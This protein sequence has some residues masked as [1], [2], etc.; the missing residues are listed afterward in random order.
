MGKNRVLWVSVKESISKST[1]L[2][3]AFTNEVMFKLRPHVL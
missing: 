2:R 1:G 3:K